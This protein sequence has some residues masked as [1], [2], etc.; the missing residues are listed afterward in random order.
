MEPDHGCAKRGCHGDHGDLY[1]GMTRHDR[2]NPE[3]F[4]DSAANGNILMNIYVGVSGL[5]RHSGGVTGVSGESIAITHVGMS[6]RIG[7]VHIVPGAQHTC[8]HARKL[9]ARG[10]ER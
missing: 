9:F 10:K 5:H 2:S 8:S 1:A 7:P 4:V 3:F 6:D